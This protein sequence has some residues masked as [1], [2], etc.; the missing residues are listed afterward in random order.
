MVDRIVCAYGFRVLYPEW[1]EKFISK[2]SQ[3]NYEAGKNIFVA[4]EFRTGSRLATNAI[5]DGKEAAQA[6]ISALRIRGSKEMK[7]NSLNPVSFYTFQMFTITACLFP[8]H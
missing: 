1:L 3:D 8:L 4:G 6:V 7:G 2:N 5:E